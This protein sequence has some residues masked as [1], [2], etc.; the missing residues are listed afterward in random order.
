[1]VKHADS[2]HRGFQFD[3]SMY[4]FKSLLV[5]KATGN[6]LMNSASL[7]K[8]GV[9]SLVSATLEIEYATQFML[10][11]IRY[12]DDTTFKSTVFEK[13]QIATSELAKTC[14]KWGLKINPKKRTVLTTE[15]SQSQNQNQIENYLIPHVDNFKF[16]GIIVPDCSS[17]IRA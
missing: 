10:T 4:H 12:A 3:S 1:M 14:H 6:H 17:G 16:L 13:L 8:L 15:N 2:Q 7:E 11:D 5:R 9:P